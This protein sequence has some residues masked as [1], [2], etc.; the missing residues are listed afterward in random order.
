MCMRRMQN[1]LIKTFNIKDA[2]T[3][4]KL[5]VNVELF[6][7]L[8]F[9]QIGPYYFLTFPRFLRVIHLNNRCC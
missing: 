5:F 8:F 2:H 3:W 1:K 7:F 4:K 6:L 9:D